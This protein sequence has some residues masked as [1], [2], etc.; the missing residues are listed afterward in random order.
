MRHVVKVNGTFSYRRRVPDDLKMLVGKDWWKASLK[1]GNERQAEIAARAL[2]VQHDQLIERLR[3]TP[4][5]E[6]AA[7]FAE[8]LNTAIDA[9]E[10]AWESSVLL[11]DPDNPDSKK[12]AE[13]EAAMWRVMLG[14]AETRYGS[15]PESDR[16][17]VEKAGGLEAFIRQH[18]A[19]AARLADTRSTLNLRSHIPVSKLPKMDTDLA[20]AKLGIESARLAKAQG[21]IERL[22]LAALAETVVE[23]PENPRINSVLDPWF[24]DR[25]QRPDAVKRHRVAMRRFVELHGNIPVRDITR[26]MIE[27]YK[28]TIKNLTD[29]RLLPAED[30][31][32]L[33]CIDGLRKVAAPTVNRHLTSIKAFL[34]YCADKEYLAKNV[35]RG[36][37]APID[38]RPKASKRRAMTREERIQ[39]LN[40]AVAEYGEDSERVWLIKLAAYTGTRLEEAAQLGRKNVRQ[41]DGVWI[42]E[43]DD[44]DGRQLKNFSS[45]RDVPL[46]SAIRDEFLAWLKKTDAP[47]RDRV[48]MTFKQKDGRFAESLSGDMGRLMDRAGITDPRVVMHS[49]RHG[50][51]VAMADA[52]I[53]GDY[54]RMILG[55]KPLDVHS[56]DYAQPSMATIAREFE[57]MGKLF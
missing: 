46:H 52:G 6:R 55:H 14:A 56:A 2:A 32:A 31:G 26:K 28:E 17:L 15:L 35:A 40:R 34:G 4:A 44:L 3:A 42:V 22:G 23:D 20:E 8:H 5:S 50:L 47:K 29:H 33:V 41:K 25:G 39:F 45:V 24:A 53:E 13:I 51:K 11:D 16:A 49:M 36:I 37:D 1:T 10:I 12:A 7:I 30:R 38:T 9:A 54:R 57:R 21:V 43:I 48:F 19:T 27:S 18:R